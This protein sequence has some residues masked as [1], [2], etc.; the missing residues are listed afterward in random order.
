MALWS[1]TSDGWGSDTSKSGNG[2]LGTY[3]QSSL[4]SAPKSPS[5][6]QAANPNN[7]MPTASV[8]RMAQPAPAVQQ[9]TGGVIPRTQLVNAPP[10][11]LA[12]GAQ[13]SVVT[14]PTFTAPTPVAQTPT[15]A[16]PTNLVYDVT[17]PVM[18]KM[19][20]YYQIDPRTGKSV[21]VG[22]QLADGQIVGVADEGR[23]K[24]II[25]GNQFTQIS[26]IN[27]DFSG[28]NDAAAVSASQAQSLKP[29]QD[30]LTAAHLANAA[31]LRTATYEQRLAYY[32]SELARTGELPPE[33]LSPVKTLDDTDARARQAA[34]A[35]HQTNTEDALNI[36]KGIQPVDT[37]QQ[38]AINQSSIA[39]LAS[40]YSTNVGKGD[41]G[42]MGRLYASALTNQTGTNKL[43]SDE[44]YA[45]GFN[46]NLS[47]FQDA[48][49][50]QSTLDAS[51]TGTKLQ[52][53]V[54]AMSDA[55]SKLTQQISQVGTSASQA[56][57]QQL[58]DAQRL[59][60]DYQ[61]KA[62]AYEANSDEAIKYMKL[63]LGVAVGISA[64]ALAPATGGASIAG[65]IAA[66]SAIVKS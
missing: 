41:V 51:A 19:K 20:R 56:V 36:S 49:E 50:K 23:A 62:S 6:A 22:D 35:Q 5:E 66:G 4:A 12:N 1:N 57:S 16:G 61:K 58:I 59:I 30:Q 44:A 33:A 9:V 26:G 45:Q 13:V 37:S 24:Q 43:L 11:Q 40:R 7:S 14:A 34:L 32:Q 25:G 15:Y 47:I 31:Q 60:Q 42:S 28:Q 2:Q 29:Y 53:D 3:L 63:A 65:G 52:S 17:D 38:D 55:V 48:V 10:A 54:Q 39:A 8:S 64:I 18:G 21:Y 27:G 46:R